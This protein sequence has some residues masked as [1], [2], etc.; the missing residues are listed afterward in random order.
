[1]STRAERRRA[2]REAQAVLERVRTN[3]GVGKGWRLSWKKRR[4]PVREHRQPVDVTRL[5]RESDKAR[6][7]IRTGVVE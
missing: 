4:Y 5:A 7:R 2:E 1:M 3:P 6:T